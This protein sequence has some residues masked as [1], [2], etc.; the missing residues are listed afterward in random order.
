MESVLPSSAT[1]PDASGRQEEQHPAGALKRRVPMQS[2]HIKSFE[3]VYEILD[4]RPQQAELYHVFQWL[5]PGQFERNNF[6]I[7]RQTP[8]ASQI[9]Y[10]LV[11]DVLPHH[12]PGICQS[13]RNISHK[14]A[15]A[16]RSI[17][18]ISAIINRLKI[19]SSWR[20]GSDMNDKGIAE[21]AKLLG[22][23]LSIL[24]VILSPQRCIVDI[25]THLSSL[26]NF[27]QRWLL[28][29]ELVALLASGRVLSVASEADRMVTRTSQS[30]DKSLWLSNGSKY[31]FWLGENLVLMLEHT[32]SPEVVH[33][34][35]RKEWLYMFERALTLA[36]RGKIKLV[37][38]DELRSDVLADQIIE[39]ILEH[40]L[41]KGAKLESVFYEYIKPA[42]MYHKKIIVHSLLRIYTR[43]HLSRDDSAGN[44]P[45]SIGSVAALIRSHMEVDNQIVE[46]L[47]EWLSKDGLVQEVAIR[48]AVLAALAEDGGKK[49]RNCLN[50]GPAVLTEISLVVNAR[51]AI[52][53]SLRSFGDKLYI[54]HA[55]I[56][57]QEGFTENLLLLAGYVHRADPQHL[58][59]L[60]RSSPYLNAI[61]NRLAASSPR[62]SMLG[63]Y[64]GTAI[65][66]LVDAPDKRMNFGVDEI[67]GPSAKRF[68]G[69]ARIQDPLGSIEDLKWEASKDEELPAEPQEVSVGH[70]LQSPQGG[71]KAPTQSKII[72]IEEIDSDS[73]IEPDDE[74]DEL[75][76][77][78]KPDSDQ[79]DSDEDPTVIERN[80]PTAPVYITDLLTYLRDTENY[81]RH[82]LALT[83]AAPLIRRKTA[84]G[85]EVTDHS[86]DLA[87]ILT[88]LQDKW[89]F[90]RFQEL[91]LQAMIAVLVAHPMEMGLWFSRSYFNGDYS[92]SQRA[93]MLTTLGL[94]AREL[95]GYADANTSL[96]KTGDTRNNE[97]SFPSKQL[98]PKLHKLY[99]PEEPLTTASNQLQASIL[100]PMALKAADALSGPNILKTR[101]FSSRM[102]VEK[103]RTRAIPNAL[104][105]VVADGFFFPL[106]GQFQAILHSMSGRSNSTLLSPML[107]PLY[108]RTL[109]LIVHAAGRSTLSL[110]QMTT[111]FLALLL[112]VRSHSSASHLSVVGALLFAF[113]TLMEVNGDREG[114]RRLA[115]E[116]G[117]EVMEMG[118]WVSGVFDRVRGGGG[119]GDE[120][121]EEDQ[122]K[123]LAAG[124]LNRVKELVESEERVL[125]GMGAGL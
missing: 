112:A 75:P 9:I 2:T 78:A 62:A 96:V 38:Y 84:F 63:M 26:P 50:Q 3:H 42:S 73:E 52:S 113:L 54:K 77:Y 51:T 15:Q 57:Q 111:E 114:M 53:E 83:H 79:S 21:R 122:V 6:D 116:Q 123:A 18:G 29:K 46:I 61:S 91:R 119:G 85:T 7:R 71:S 107:L 11:N 20:D 87:A 69:L 44:N 19:L 28:W 59:N 5:L 125:M 41:H 103:R 33:P 35:V 90:A 67:H 12:W 13:S 74:D 39:Q 106:T 47:L 100:Q 94:G 30:V 60:T 101:T 34:E 115:Q 45:K 36:H 105:K 14:V 88:G 4:S 121:S 89:N 124:C 37:P 93:M 118:Q 49:F 24:D 81:D 55:S 25:W 48:R 65:S 92:V 104:A 43:N 70:K 27:S 23:T 32:S 82:T 117:R 66:E 8:Q 31:C 1:R 56:L 80:K 108:L 86:K 98:P 110:Q 22:S 95:A 40:V 68:T 99:A 10:K 109:A 16:L 58:L 17:G 120:H 64:V 97:H 102:E 72:A 76:V